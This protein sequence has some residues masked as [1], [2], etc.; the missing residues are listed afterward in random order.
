MAFLSGF[1]RRKV[2]SFG[3]KGN[4][5]LLGLGRDGCGFRN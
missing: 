2:G 4:G 1:S 5:F 3:E